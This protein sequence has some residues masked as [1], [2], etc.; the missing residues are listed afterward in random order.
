MNSINIQTCFPSYFYKIRFINKKI[1]SHTIQRIAKKTYLQEKVVTND[2]NF[3]RTCL[4]SV[5]ICHRFL[6]SKNSSKRHLERIWH[7]LARYFPTVQETK[8]II[9]TPWLLIV[10]WRSAILR[11]RPEESLHHRHLHRGFEFNAVL[12]VCAA[13][14]LQQSQESQYVRPTFGP[15][16]PELPEKPKH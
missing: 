10:N 9:C 11:V 2:T 4:H 8:T 13:A 5:S 6:L 3:F 7:T 16:S 12:R 14:Q 1:S 15:C